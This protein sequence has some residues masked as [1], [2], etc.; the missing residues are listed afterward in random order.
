MKSSTDEHHQPTSLLVLG[1]PG[2]GKTTLI[3]QIPGIFILDCD[4]NLAGPLRWRKEQAIKEEFFYGCPLFDDDDNPLPREEWFQRSASLLMEASADDRVKALAIDSLSSFTEFVL[5]EVLRQQGRK[6]GDLT[7]TRKGAKIGDDQMQ[8]Q[9]WGVFFNVMKQWI[10]KIKGSGKTTVITGH[11]KHAEDSVTGMVRQAVAVPGQLADVISGFF[12]EVWL[13]E[14]EIERT[15]DG[16]VENR[17][18]TTFPQNKQAKGLGL[19]SSA[20]IKSGE[21]VNAEKLLKVFQ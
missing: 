11:I 3:S 1:P 12:S 20:G 2:T 18:I 5:R 14:N 19:K 16:P 10:F 8:I 21:V 4:N 6:M 9:D 15:K 13:L 7:L 17:I